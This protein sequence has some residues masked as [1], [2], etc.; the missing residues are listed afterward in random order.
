MHRVT[1]ILLE[2]LALIL[3]FWLY[4]KLV[5]HFKLYNTVGVIISLSVVFLGTKILNKINLSK[6][7]TK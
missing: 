5:P 2:F 4:T 3:V 6:N 7:S 1:A